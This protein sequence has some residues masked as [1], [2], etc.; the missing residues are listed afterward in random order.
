MTRVLISGH[1]GKM[2]RALAQSIKDRDD[3]LLAAGVD[4]MADSNDFDFPSYTGFEQVKTQVDLIIDFSNPSTLDA[5]L[6]F[7]I[8]NKLPLV[9]ATTGFSEE[10]IEKISRAAEDIPLFFSANMSLGVSLLADL[11]QKAA[12]VLGSA[13]DIEIVEK[14]HNQKIDAPSG[15]ALMLADSVSQ[16]FKEKPKYVY[17]RH[18][19]REKRSKNEVGIHAIRGGTITGEHDVIFAGP[20]EILTLSHSAGS[21]QIFA[22]GAISAA[23]FIRG[24]KPG[25]Y[26]MSDLVEAEE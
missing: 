8:N 19:K 9:I 14:H 21:R 16:A 18:S 6:A 22:T 3:C 26:K 1:A 2:G 24:K 7:A 10:Q 11:A 4:I 13:F 25:L 23:L 5:L 20:D 12:K 17:E 15:T